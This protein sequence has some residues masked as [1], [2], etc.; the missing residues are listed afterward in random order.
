MSLLSDIAAEMKK[1][2]NKCDLEHS[3]SYH[4]WNL[5]IEEL[6]KKHSKSMTIHTDNITPDKPKNIDNEDILIGPFK[7]PFCKGIGSTNQFS[8]NIQ[9]EGIKKIDC[10]LCKGK[11]EVYYHCY[12]R[13]FMESD[14]EGR[15]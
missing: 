9:T 7:C 8:G 14:H 5:K 3:Q 12:W 6:R 10:L 1:V 4:R 15:C 13:G 2:E 11:R